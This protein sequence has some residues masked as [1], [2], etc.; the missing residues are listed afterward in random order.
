MMHGQDQIMFQEGSNFDPRTNFKRDDQ[1][2]LFQELPK[3]IFDDFF[4]TENE[5]NPELYPDPVPRVK[6]NSKGSKYN[7]IDSEFGGN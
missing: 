4:S 1:S 3:E 6:L 5:A 2:Q 7:S